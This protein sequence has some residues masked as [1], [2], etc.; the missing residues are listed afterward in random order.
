MGWL[1]DAN[2]AYSQAA[3][4]EGQALRSEGNGP[5]LCSGPQLN[6]WSGQQG[7]SLAP[8]RAPQAALK[9]FASVPSLLQ[10]RPSIDTVS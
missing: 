3:V 9:L 7:K 2:R 8:L 5:V 6:F 10:A 4:I 1:R